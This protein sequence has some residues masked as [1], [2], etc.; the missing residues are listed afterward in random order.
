MFEYARTKMIGERVIER[1][2]NENNLVIGMID[3][4]LQ[5]K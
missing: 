2:I 1:R 3:C 5:Y 4:C